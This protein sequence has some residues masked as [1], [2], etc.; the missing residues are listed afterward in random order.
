MADASES[1]AP[2]WSQLLTIADYAR[3]CSV[4]AGHNVSRQAVLKRLDSGAL[5]A[6]TQTIGSGKPRRYIDTTVHPPGAGPGRWPAR[7]PGSVPLPK[8]E[9]K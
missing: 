1:T 8:K 6:V 4:E 2:K 5:T 7:P 9:K 3:A